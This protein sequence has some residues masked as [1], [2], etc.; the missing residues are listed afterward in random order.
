VTGVTGGATLAVIGALI[1]SARVSPT[2]K[3]PDW[4]TRAVSIISGRATPTYAVRLNAPTGEPRFGGY[5]LQFTVQNN[6]NRDITIP[7]DAM[8][9]RRL[10]GGGAFVDSSRFAKP[11]KAAFVPA[12]Q[13]TELDIKVEWN[14]FR[15]NPYGESRDSDPEACYRDLWAG[16]VAFELFDQANHL[17]VGLP[18][19]ALTAS[20]PD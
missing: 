5:L 19:P 16:G 13:Q 3:P 12:H 8:I 11:F 18:K 2:A 9:M 10:Y 7:A 17:Q 4:D 15:L 6:T 14:C 1:T 20:P